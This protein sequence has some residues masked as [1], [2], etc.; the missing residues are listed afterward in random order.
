MLPNYEKF[1]KYR[2]ELEQYYSVLEG[3]T[4]I[5]IFTSKDQ[6]VINAIV[7]FGGI[8]M[9]DSRFLALNQDETTTFKKENTL[10]YSLVKPALKIKAKHYK[11]KVPKMKGM[12]IC[13]YSAFCLYNNFYCDEL[14]FYADSYG[15][16]SNL[17]IFYDR[18]IKPGENIISFMYNNQIITIIRIN[19]F[20]QI[21][22]ELN[23]FK[24]IYDTYLDQYTTSRK[25]EFMI[26]TQTSMEEF[27]P[28]YNLICPFIFQR[29]S[30]FGQYLNGVDTDI[31]KQR[32]L[33][34]KIKNVFRLNRIEMCDFENIGEIQ[35]K[36]S[37]KIV[38]TKKA[39]FDN[40]YD[41]FLQIHAKSV[42]I[43]IDLKYILTSFF[44]YNLE[45]YSFLKNY[46]Q[47]IEFITC[48]FNS[49][50]EILNY[51]DDIVLDMNKKIRYWDEKDETIKESYFQENEECIE[52]MINKN[53][54][55]IIN[56]ELYKIRVLFENETVVLMESSFM[57]S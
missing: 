18:T 49:I 33:E 32:I 48:P 47:N 46:F 22:E 54:P 38:I 9:Y 52:K 50:E 45:E 30:K 42:L 39:Q 17:L 29:G 35:P 16:F 7:V 23:E 56:E 28:G 8:P 5:E 44:P 20:A 13:G 27:I 51:L 26:K 24:I 55:T 12:Y 53:E 34:Y 57:I 11:M 25:Y 2:S 1:K 6:K 37:N 43:I 19:T 3:K 21:F 41:R 10:S 40:Q 15:V 36:V 4:E 31:I 14:L